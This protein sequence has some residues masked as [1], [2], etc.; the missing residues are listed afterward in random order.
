MVLRAGLGVKK[1][2]KLD[3]KQIPKTISEIQC[4]VFN[5]QIGPSVG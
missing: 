4:P 5:I 2:R 1:R 3:V